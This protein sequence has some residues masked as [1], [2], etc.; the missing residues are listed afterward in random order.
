MLVTLP[1]N[2]LQQMLASN[3]AAGP[4]FGRRRDDGD[5]VQIAGL[6]PADGE[7]LGV[8]RRS[9]SVGTVPVEEDTICLIIDDAEPP[10]VR[11]L[12]AGTSPHC[13]V[14]RSHADYDARLRG[15]FE[16][17][18]LRNSRVAV[19]GL[20]SGGSLVALMLARS[21]LG[22]IHLVD[23]DRL[24]TH[25]IARHACGLDDIGRYKT[26]A[27]ADLLRSVS[28]FIVTRT[29]EADVL[30]DRAALIQAIEGC[31]LVVAATD[32]EQSKLAINRACW[33]LGIPVVYG[34][35]YN[36]AF[37]GDIFRAVPPEAACYNCLHINA[38][39]MFAPPPAATSDFGPGYADPA[40]MQDLIAEPGLALD[41]GM[42]A[43]L[44]GRVALYTLLGA[45]APPGY[46]LPGNWLLFGNRAEWLFDEPLQR[47]FIDV[48]RDD[49]CP[50]CNYP[51]YVQNAIGES[52]EAVAAKAADILTEAALD[53]K[54]S[55]I[56]R[57]SD[58]H[59][60][61]GD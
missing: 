21:G 59:H 12:A 6:T 2:L 18:R 48:P 19:I 31:N 61:R 57:T 54:A 26:R 7:E 47:L 39:E 5:L 15:I 53:G 52:V 45:A 11:V 58:V 51:G 27:V 36:R 33:P 37:G 22:A 13:V 29:W 44:L 46:A 16:S 25:N 43:L 35:A 42:I 9:A 30:S 34:A 56:V 40:R 28:P 14:V 55:P 20:G 38:A 60:P 41:V 32:S 17:D 1:D 8:W 23:H 24:K 50:I 49:Q 4:I 10:L 3:E